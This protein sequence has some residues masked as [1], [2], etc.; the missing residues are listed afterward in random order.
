VGAGPA[1]N[2]GVTTPV[3]AGLPPGA[4]RPVLHV[5]NTLQTGG[6]EYLVLNLARVLDRRRFPMF[7]CSLQG[8]GEIGHELRGLG[9]PTFVLQRRVGIDPFLLPSLVGLIR[10]HQVRIVHTHNVAP[11]LYAGIAARLTGAAVCHTEHSSLFPE[12]RAL[13]KAEWVLAH[14]T[15]AVIC[16]GEDVRRQLV[17]EQRLSPRNVVT[18]YNGVDTALYGR[19]VDRAGGRRAL[20]LDERAPVVGTVARLE[21]VKDQASLLEAFAQVGARIPTARLVVVGDGSQ[22]AA[23]EE[24]ARQPALAGRVLFLGRRAD[25]ASVLP[26][27]DAFVLSSVSEGLPLTILEAMAAGL[28]CVSTAVGAVPEAIV[29]GQ[30]GHLV[31]PRAP[32][33]LATALG[34]LLADLPRARALGAA[35]QRR[36]RELFDLQAMTRRY[37]DLYAA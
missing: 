20:G 9:V 16:D 31:P 37:E 2:G 32:V 25:V 6:A 5:L 30:T 13:K 28:P 10:R 8:D 4:T 14:L 33:A 27:F 21:P 7:V 36:A 15:K 19:P 34:N 35:G 17:E 24:Q 29:E 18:V 23:L 3:G 26:L 22:R 11:W 12:Q 1:S